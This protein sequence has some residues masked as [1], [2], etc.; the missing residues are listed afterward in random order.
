MSYV[1]VGDIRNAMRESGAL[2]DALLQ[3]FIDQEEA[4]VKAILRLD[5]FPPDNLILKE[6]IR[7]LVIA[8][9][10]YNITPANSD[11]YAMA[12]SLR[13]EALRRLQEVDNRG[14][15]PS[16]SSGGGYGD[17]VYNPW[18]GPLFRFE[19]YLP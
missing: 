12:V 16:G 4:Y 2:P 9:A 10:I 11:R 5:S 15:I 7:D 19:D 8:R 17:E 18:E 3:E 13:G 14:L 6:I 1:T